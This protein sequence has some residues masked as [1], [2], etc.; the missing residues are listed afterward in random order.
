MIRQFMLRYIH[1]YMCVCVCVCVCV[2]A[3][4][5]VAYLVRD[6][7]REGAICCRKCI[8]IFKEMSTM[9]GARAEA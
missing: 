1:T 4:V 6:K 9:L 8:D 2:C 3:C 7:G 5:C